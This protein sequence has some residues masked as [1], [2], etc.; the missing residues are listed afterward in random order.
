M[1]NLEE[2]GGTIHVRVGGNTQETASLVDYIP[3][4]RDISK[5]YSRTSNPVS[6]NIL[7]FICLQVVH[8]QLWWDADGYSTFR[9]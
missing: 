1:S 9:L 7:Y 2:R 4:Y 8:Y 3:D 6:L 5:D